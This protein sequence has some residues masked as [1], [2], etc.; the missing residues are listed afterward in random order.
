MSL[1]LLQASIFVTALSHFFSCCYYPIPEG[2]CLIRTSTV[3]PSHTYRHIFFTPILQQYYPFNNGIPSN[4][5]K[6]C[7]K[8]A[9]CV[10]FSN[11]FGGLIFK[12]GLC[13]VLRPRDHHHKITYCTQ[14]CTQRPIHHTHFLCRVYSCG[15]YS[16]AAYMQ[17]NPPKREAF[18]QDRLI[19][20]GG[21]YTR[22]YGTYN[23]V[24]NSATSQTTLKNKS[25]IGDPICEVCTFTGHNHKGTPRHIAKLT[26]VKNKFR[27]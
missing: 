2:P 6:S 9:A 3:R 5:V 23:S 18:I 4:T 10:Q 25:V 27:K 1:L 22:L 20:K 21:F 12:T 7:I 26:T 8:A 24:D 19:F 16:R 15:F 13:A 17:H 14:L 11:F